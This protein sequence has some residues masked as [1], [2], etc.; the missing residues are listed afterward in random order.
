MAKTRPIEELSYEEAIS[1]L[2]T[3]VKKLETGNQPL[4]ESMEIFVRG[5][6]L[7]KHCGELL[8]KAELK[9]RQLTG[10]S[11]EDIEVS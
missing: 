10:D 11:V 5:Q 6:T 4:D 1:E 9:I 3:I 2:E 7:V 8:A